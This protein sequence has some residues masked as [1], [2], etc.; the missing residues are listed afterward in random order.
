MQQIC[1]VLQRC[2]RLVLPDLVLLS[3]ITTSIVNLL[4]QASVKSELVGAFC[5]SNFIVMHLYVCENKK[6]YLA[7]LL[8][9]KQFFVC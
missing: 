5:W 1:V 7:S 4:V 9:V 2:G 8:V 3:H 6:Y